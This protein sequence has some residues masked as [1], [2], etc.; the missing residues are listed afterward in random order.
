MAKI[1]EY[2]KKDGSVAYQ[3]Q[4]YVGIDP[5]TGKRIRTTRR[6]LPSQKIAELELAKINL[7]IADGTFKITA[8]ADTF[9]D[10]SELWLPNYRETV[11][12]VT[13]CSTVSY[14]K[15]HILP[16]F[17]DKKIDKINV[18]FCQQT[19]NEWYKTMPKSF[20]R[21]VNYVSKI[22]DF[23]I[24]MEITETNPMDKV[25]IPNVKEKKSKYGFY[26]KKELKHFLELVH[27]FDPDMRYAFF[28]LLAYSGM[29]KGEA[30]ALTWED[31][32]FKKNIIDI[33]K[34][35]S[36]GENNTLY[37]SPPKNKSSIRKISMDKVTMNILK[38]WKIKQLEYFLILG[39]HPKK[40]DQ[41]VFATE[42][43]SY[44]HPTIDNH[45]RKSIYK[46]DPT[47]KKI[48]THDLRHTHCSLLFEAGVSPVEVK[49]RLGHAD[50]T[51]TMNIYAHVTEARRDE[52]ADKFEAFME[53]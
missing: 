27:E 23:A 35:L 19:V 51:T 49:D 6:G 28:R 39:K 2:R 3:F 25:I 45:W 43:N 4:V 15:L 37:V 40:K 32:D 46:L 38:N 41:I 5:V 1:K 50:I 11:E 12:E 53:G 34:S 47:F 14:L 31:I 18:A 30:Y 48:R 52:T 44:Y 16:A 24:S 36:R 17:G 21:Y 22:F 7:A 29:R 13:Y 9:E 42:E 10:V 26:A 20:K 8:P 33:N